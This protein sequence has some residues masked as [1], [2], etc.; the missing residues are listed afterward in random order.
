MNKSTYIYIA[1]ICVISLL[2]LQGLWM[3]AI[4]RNYTNLFVQDAE[5]AL[6]ISI[7]KE[8]SYRNG[9]PY[10][11]PQNPKVAIKYAKEMTPE[12]RNSLKGDTIDF[13]E[14]RMKNIG[15]DLNEIMVQIAQD[16]FIRT[17]KFINLSILDS[18]F[19]AEM[20][21]K[22]LEANHG[23][24][25][26][27]KDTTVIDQT[28]N[29][30]LI[31]QET[32]GTRLFP[33]G[34]KGLQFIQMKADIPLSTF[35]KESILIVSTSFLLVV[36]A[37]GCVI[38]FGRTIRRKDRLFKQRES[39]V[40]GTVHDL[41]A[42]LNSIITL[43][44]FIRKKQPDEGSKQLIDQTMHQAKSLV[45]DIESLLITA[46]RDRQ[47]I[48]LQRTETDLVMLVHRAQESLSALYTGKP[49]TI[50]IIAEKPVMTVPVDPLYTTNVIRNL[51]ENALKYSDDGVE[52]RVR[53]HTAEKHVKLEVADNGWGIEKK[54]Q[55]KIFKQ[56]FQ[57][58][59]IEK[60]L[61]R[62]YG[63]GLAYV[64]YIMEAHGGKITVNSEPGKGS[65]F[66]CFFP[67]K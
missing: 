36:I 5:K 51:L 54:Y 50:Q 11:N 63:V 46:R 48:L 18:L 25:L 33:I 21:R 52:I 32:M 24:F 45:S 34:T 29:L 27:D 49:H 59:R 28:G 57:V 17:G 40:N 44:S 41:K 6:S 4:H 15:N 56:F 8:L 64:W 61:P 1:I 14:L 7:G 60:Q 23:I 65:V 13:K 53:I 10:K 47:Q 3:N 55:K 16:G 39:S 58:P 22:G 2:A 38:Y 62:G 12:E 9:N 30:Q 31:E 35:L 37:L 19:Q 66:T 42:P 26:Y 67:I 20:Q 43:M